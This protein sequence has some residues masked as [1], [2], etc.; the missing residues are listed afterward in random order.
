MTKR[1][2]VK[3]PAATRT[4]RVSH[5]DACPPC[6]GNPVSAAR[7]AFCFADFRQAIRR[8]SIDATTA[9]RIFRAHFTRLG[10][11][12]KRE[13][14]SLEKARTINAALECDI[15]AALRREGKRGLL[16]AYDSVDEL[17]KELK[18]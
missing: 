13:N 4:A 12:C 18:A 2:V 15:D 6:R 5:R 3:K 17:L 7:T 8:G 10:E 1:K 14:C 9:R 11:I 16:R